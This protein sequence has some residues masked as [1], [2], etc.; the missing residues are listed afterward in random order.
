MRPKY[1]N[2]KIFNNNNIIQKINNNFNQQ[3]NNIKNNEK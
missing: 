3:Y 2:E 1:Q